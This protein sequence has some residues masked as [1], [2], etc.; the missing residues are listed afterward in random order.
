MKLLVTKAQEKE[1]EENQGERE[2][3][4]KE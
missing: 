1:G 3:A 4:H 2:D